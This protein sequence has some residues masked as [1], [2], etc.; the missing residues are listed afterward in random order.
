MVSRAPSWES[1]LEVD[2]GRAPLER[3]AEFSAG[4]GGWPLSAA[5]GS[6]PC[7]A[8]AHWLLGSVAQLGSQVGTP[9][10]I[11]GRKSWGVGCK[12]PKPPLSWS[13][14]EPSRWARAGPAADSTAQFL[15]PTL[16]T[17][18]PQPLSAAPSQGPLTPSD[19]DHCLPERRPAP[20]RACGWLEA[21][22]LVSWLPLLG[23][24]LSNEQG[25]LLEP[26]R[27]TLARPGRDPH[28]QP[29][30]LESEK[31][32]ARRVFTTAAIS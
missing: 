22:W 24:G 17:H 5:K 8:G 11:L 30:S 6:T 31:T 25:H 15:P 16:R 12:F 4:G 13:E 2:L 14:P 27:L 28:S 3:H 21:R 29:A 10:F 20:G 23:Q 1:E 26:L 32:A 18:L 19:C 7:Q 9:W